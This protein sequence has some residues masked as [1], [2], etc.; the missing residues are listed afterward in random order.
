MRKILSLTIAF[1]TLLAAP[2]AAATELYHHKDGSAVAFFSIEDP[3]GCIRTD[4]TI[5]AYE[6]LTRSGPGPFEPAPGLMVNIDRVDWCNLVFLMS[7][8]G[9][10][11]DLEIAVRSSLMNASAQG[12]V[13]LYD[14]VGGTYSSAEV[15]L[16]WS[17]K[18]PVTIST[19]N[20][21]VYGPS[22]RS[23]ARGS[24]RHRE[25]EV[26]GVVLQDGVDLAA[27]ATGKG[28]LYYEQGS[29]VTITRDAASATAPL[30]A[31]P[32]APTGDLFSYRGGSASAGFVTIDPTGC[33]TTEIWAG[34]SDSRERYSVGGFEPVSQVG[35]NINR[36]DWCNAVELMQASWVDF[37]GSLQISNALHDAALQ[38][39]VKL[40]DSVQGLYFTVD[41]DL[42][43]KG[44][45]PL[46]GRRDRLFAD[47]PNSRSMSKEIGRSRDAEASGAV[48]YQGTN[49]LTG[50]SQSGNLFYGQGM[51]LRW[52]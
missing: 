46:S 16:D 50:P 1:A 12:R 47:F 43:W 35:V 7:A 4:I 18:G 49:L 21:L 13:Q 14:Y 36:I 26:T 24:S 40:Y 42:T 41:V 8:F 10:S 28:D 38:G 31:S 45:G 22:T 37:T 25:T 51:T 6:S 23:M 44:V 19:D 32:P 17:G 52:R 3:A 20:N 48:V 2:A 33:I 34:G 30:P 11:A 29:L 39:T 27:G 15:D 9:T 5:N